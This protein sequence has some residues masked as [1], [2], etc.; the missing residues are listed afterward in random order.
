MTQEKI[1][2][3][4]GIDMMHMIKHMAKSWWKMFFAMIIFAVLLGGYSY[5]KNAKALKNNQKKETAEMV[6]TENDEAVSLIRN[7]EEILE[8]SGLSQKAADEVLYYTNKYYYNK[9]QYERQINY[10][11]DSIL[12][13][14]D[15]NNVWTITLYYDLSVPVAAEGGMGQ[16]S[17]S[18]IAASYIAKVSNAETYDLI[19]EE[20]GADIDSGY[21]AEVITGSCLDSLS[22]VEDVTVLS[23]KEDMKILIRYVDQPGCE[24]IAEIIKERIASVNGA[25]VSEVG[26]HQITLVG[27][28]E[29]QK[30]DPELLNDQKNAIAA[31]GNLS[32]SVIS[33]RTNIE[34]SEE[35]VFNELVKY[36]QLRDA[37]KENAIQSNASSE[38]QEDSVEVDDISQKEE[39]Q[40]TVNQA[41]P[42]ISKK[43][44]ALGMFL[45]IFLVAVYE[46]CKY[47]FSHTLKQKR[48]LEE[49]YGLAVYDSRDKA[50]IT[51]VMRSKSEK[52]G[53]KKI[54]TVSSRR[55]PAQDEEELKKL[56][57]A[58]AIMLEEKL[59]VS[60]H[61]EI[62]ELLELCKNLEKPV[63][64]AVVEA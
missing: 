46:A 22:D 44:V 55:N 54:Y 64:G 14:M 34:A 24:K 27:E 31:L 39:E 10:L 51:L 13:Q 49:A 20:L 5:Y 37:E 58:D 52:N 26:N 30:S 62:A 35:G 57:E 29:E 12:M 9:K 6:Q 17:D 23:G 60:S 16:S 48:E 32:D 18:A 28:R 4:E 53:W 21:F 36:Y 11:Q 40:E 15:P 1:R 42:Q 25:V 7:E 59:N 45:G 3:Y 56:M 38:N 61:L 19:A 47:F 33:A 50:V 41:K 43:Y 8:G 2:P 63:I